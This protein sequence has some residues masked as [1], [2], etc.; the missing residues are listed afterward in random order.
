MHRMSTDIAAAQGRR[1]TLTMAL[2]LTLWMSACTGRLLQDPVIEPL[3]NEHMIIVTVTAGDTLENLAETHLGDSAKAW[4]IAAYNG[5][6]AFAPGTQVVIP[7][8]PIVPGG[9][10]V[11][12]YQTIPILMYERI[13]D[14]ID[15]SAVSAAEFEAQ[16][17]YLAGNGFSALNLT[18]LLAFLDLDDSIP[19]GAVVITLEGSEPWVYDIAYPIL[20]RHGLRAALFTVP[21]AIGQPGRLTW[22]SLRAMAADGFDIGLLGTPGVR[23]VSPQPPAESRVQRMAREIGAGRQALQAGLDRSCDFFAYP[24]RADDVIVTYISKQGFRAAFTR[25]SG[26]NAFFS[27]PFRLKRQLVGAETDLNRFERL[28]VTFHSA[29]LR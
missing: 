16:M 28:L 2:T 24:G 26:A 19:P 5:A 6:D 17:A 21:E 29:E 22:E 23:P 14:G 3:S 13:A 7:R 18:A 9:L 15:S 12:G 1:L 27:D 10:R 11:D 20:K 25:E 4:W 8:R